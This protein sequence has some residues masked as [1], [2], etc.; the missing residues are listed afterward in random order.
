MRRKYSLPLLGF[1]LVSNSCSN[2]LDG[3][4]ESIPGAIFN[5]VTDSVFKSK[6][7]KEIDSDT[8]RMLNGEPLKYFPSEKRLRSVRENRFIDRMQ[9]DD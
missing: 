6:K 8:T 1:I 9:E 2:I 5:G 3:M 7:D 4:I